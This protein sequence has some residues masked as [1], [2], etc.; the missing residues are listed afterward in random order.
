MLIDNHLAVGPGIGRATPSAGG[1]VVLCL[2]RILR[3][4]Q[5]GEDFER[6]GHRSACLPV[7]RQG[8]LSPR[9]GIIQREIVSHEMC[10]LAH[11]RIDGIPYGRQIELA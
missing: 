10:L 2:Y 7:Q 3:I 11:R 8:D 6:E 1:R 9:M 4:Y 5:V